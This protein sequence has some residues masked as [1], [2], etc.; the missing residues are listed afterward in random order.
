MVLF[1]SQSF[2]FYKAKMNDWRKDVEVIVNPVI[3]NTD[4]QAQ[5]QLQR[6]FELLSELY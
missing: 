4:T 3:Q 2:V 1:I 6:I 5:A